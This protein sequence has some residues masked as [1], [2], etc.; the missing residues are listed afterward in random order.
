MR[1]SGRSSSFLMAFLTKLGQTRPAPS[2]PRSPTLAHQTLVA[3]FF[4]GGSKVFGEVEKIAVLR[5][6]GRRILNSFCSEVG[7]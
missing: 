2:S 4:A 3:L 1:L 5:L 7:G 6:G